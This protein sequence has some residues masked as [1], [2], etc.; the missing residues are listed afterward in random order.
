MVTSAGIFLINKEGKILIGHPT[1]HS[2][3]SWSI[4]K[5]K[6]DEGETEYEAAVRETWEESNMDVSSVT[7]YHELDK[8][9]YN[10]KKKQLKPYVILETENPELDLE[11][12]EVKCNANVPEEKGGYPEMDDFK[13]VDVDEARGLLHHTQVAC[14]DEVASIINETKKD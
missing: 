5:G 3:N 12:A 11:T 14:L 6:L 10:H 7:T 9:V 13:W 4:P 8:K 1:K 2:N